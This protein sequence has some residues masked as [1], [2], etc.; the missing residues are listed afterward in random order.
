MLENEFCKRFATWTAIERIFEEFAY[1]MAL[2][3]RYWL[4]DNAP[5]S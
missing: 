4:F 3:R 1:V 5:Y 2:S